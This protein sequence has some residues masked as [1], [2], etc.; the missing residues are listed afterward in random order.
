MFLCRLLRWWRGA[1]IDFIIDATVETF[2]HIL[3]GKPYWSR[4]RV[5]TAR[6]IHENRLLDVCPACRTQKKISL[7][8][9]AQLLARGADERWLNNHTTWRGYVT[10]AIVVV[11]LVLR[12]TFVLERICF[13]IWRVNASQ[14]R[15][16][17]QLKLFFA[18]Q[19]SPKRRIQ[20]KQRFFLNGKKRKYYTASY[21]LANYLRAVRVR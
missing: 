20:G 13:R 4:L 8:R 11:A 9:K 15:N 1:Q 10:D 16:S 18:L 3:I 21:W 6:S 17:Y 7:V 14:Y 12:F 19:V 2:I 5:Y